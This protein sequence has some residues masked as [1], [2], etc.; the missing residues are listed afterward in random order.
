MTYDCLKLVLAALRKKPKVLSMTGN[1]M[2][3]SFTTL[4]A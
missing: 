1:F 2:L 3:M 4:A